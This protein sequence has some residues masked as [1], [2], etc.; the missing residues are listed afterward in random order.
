MKKLPALLALAVILTL[1]S[2]KKDHFPFPENPRIDIDFYGLTVNNEIVKIEGKN[3]SR[4][5]N[6]TSITGL[7]SDASIIAIDFRP[8]TGQLYGLGSNK[9][10]YTINYTTGLA[11]PIGEEPFATELDGAMVG[12]DFNPTVDRIRL[13]TSLGKNLRLHP[14]TGSLVAMDGTINPGGPQIT[15]VAYCNSFAGATSTILYDIDA[16][17]DKLYKQDP[18]ND[19]KLVEVGNLEV[20]FSGE[21]GFDISPD[22]KYA[23]ATLNEGNKYGSKQKLYRIDLNKG[24][25]TLVCELD[26]PLIG[27]AIPTRPVAYAA[28]LEN[29]LV[30]FDPMKIGTVIKKPFSGLQAGET[31]VGLDMRPATGQLYALGSTNRLYA[32]NMS[33]GVA[34][35]I[36]T[37]PFSAVAAGVSYGFDFNPTVDRI[38]IVGS[39]GQNMRVH[40]VTGLLAAMDANLNPGTPKIS[41]AAYT[42]SLAGATSTTLFDIDHMTGKLYKQDP[43]N[44][45]K[46]VEVGSLG[47]TITVSNGFDIGGTS[48]QGYALLSSGNSTKLYGIN[49]TTGKAEA[50]GVFPGKASAFTI[51]LGF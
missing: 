15:A 50:K 49:L 16:H 30:I 10:L 2:C 13:V 44:D 34:S 40:P 20:D 36:S 7:P 51:G 39:N 32:V 41:A 25:A 14:E 42:N 23:L 31:V 5:T 47:I 6:V 27:L 17:A 24:K 21:S 11:S 48:N 29:N 18:P 12:F 37:T 35:A 3:V 9:R 19:G 28:D 8:A 26:K 45:G 1:S 46:L 38:R 33:S 4:A 43:P 22:N